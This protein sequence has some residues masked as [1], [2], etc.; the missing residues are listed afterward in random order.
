MSAIYERIGKHGGSP[1]D[2]EPTGLRAV[3]RRMEGAT[4]HGRIKGECGETMEVFLKVNGERIEEAAFLTDGC[5]SSVLCG[6]LATRLA[7]GKTLDEAVEIA[8]DTILMHLPNLPQSETHCAVLAAET[9][10]AAIHQ[11]MV[12][13]RKTP[14]KP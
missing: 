8:G 1:R 7:E 3:M 12:D 11:W 9:L 13:D 10:H 4:C 6:Y 5:D 2:E 14:S